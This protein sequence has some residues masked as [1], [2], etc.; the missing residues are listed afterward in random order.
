MDANFRA[1]RTN[2][3]VGSRKATFKFRGPPSDVVIIDQYGVYMRES[4]YFSDANCSVI[5]A[6][7]DEEGSMG[8]FGKD[9]TSGLDVV[10]KVPYLDIN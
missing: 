7:V 5:E 2:A 3:I 1:C 4:T 10:S 9:A 8:Y 6:T